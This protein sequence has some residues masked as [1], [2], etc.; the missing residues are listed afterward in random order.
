MK[1]IRKG[2]DGLEVEEG[3]IVEIEGLDYKINS[4]HQSS[5]YARI[6]MSRVRKH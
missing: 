1:E 3:S 6:R 4:L 2:E 5:D